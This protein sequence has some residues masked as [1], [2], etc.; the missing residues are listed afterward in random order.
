MT[1]KRLT[2]EEV[3][4]VAVAA[5]RNAAKLLT[6][7]NILL[8]ADRPR[9]AYAL[10]VIAVEEAAKCIECRLLLE[11]WTGDLTVA[12]LND[13]LKPRRDAHLWRYRRTLQYLAATGLIAGQRLEGWKDLDRIARA[14]MNARE[15]ALYVEVGPSGLRQ[16]PERVFEAE[17]RSWLID[18]IAVISM[19]EIAWRPQ[20]N[21]ALATARGESPGDQ[22]Q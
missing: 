5:I 15:H 14:D 2:P 18:M 9:T 6:D 12:Q 16:T 4:A 11:S 1:S 10:G 13:R 22:G 17:A 7:A 19:T 3:H 21:R 20:L 8:E